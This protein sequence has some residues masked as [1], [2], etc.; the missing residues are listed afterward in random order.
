MSTMAAREMYPLT[1]AIRSHVEGKAVAMLIEPEACLH[2]KARSWSALPVA[3]LS[4]VF[5]RF[6]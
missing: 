4:E 1:D 3:S 6:Q 2:T 5:L